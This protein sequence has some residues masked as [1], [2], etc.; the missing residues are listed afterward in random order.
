MKLLGL[1]LSC[2]VGVTGVGIINAQCPELKET[3]A[4]PRFALE[5]PHE[6][7]PPE[8]FTLNGIAKGL[9]MI[10][11]D[12][13]QSLPIAAGTSRKASLLGLEPTTTDDRVSITVI[14]F[15]GEYN[16]QNWRMSLDTLENEQ[17]GTYS[18]KLG[19]TLT[20]SSMEQVGLQPLAIKVVSALPDVAYRPRI[21][22]KAPSFE[23]T[24]TPVDRVS[25]WL[26]IQS[27]SDRPVVSIMFGSLNGGAGWTQA[28]TATE[29]LILPG[30]KYRNW[31]QVQGST[32]KVNGEYVT[33]LPETIN[34]EAVLFSDLSFEGD[35]HMALSLAVS[36]V[37]YAA[38]KR[39]MWE[40]SIPI[41]ADTQKTDA[42]KLEELRAAARQIPDQP[43][44]A[45]MD[46]LRIR[47]SGVTDRELEQAK[48]TMS[49]AI[50]TQKELFEHSFKEFEEN[51]RT[52]PKLTL[53]LWW[54]RTQHN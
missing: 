50:H 6:S 46:D 5:I 26:T 28:T 53:A 39:R 16:H 48:Q 9:I 8:Y 45:L 11:A 25:G 3:P 12:Q 47:F 10:P 17:L 14:A 51:S 1:S 32:G 21:V 7:R 36:R 29:A 31:F 15:F 33:T 4:P 40:T 24:F 19:D 43:D 34:L 30:C 54:A 35:P 22:S 2:L 52:H 13:L 37:G 42:E 20:A 23:A 27:H 18:G 38:V 41:L 44:A 49:A